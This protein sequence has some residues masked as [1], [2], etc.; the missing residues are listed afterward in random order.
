MFLK[1]WLSN[2]DKFAVIATILAT[3]IVLG[4]ISL[5]IYSFVCLGFWAT[6]GIIILGLFAIVA[7]IG[8]ICIIAQLAS[9]INEFLNDFWG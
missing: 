3:V 2:I 7:I 4:G 5:L 6:V 8:V 1:K 9:V